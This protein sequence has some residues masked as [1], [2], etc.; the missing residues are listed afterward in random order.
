[1]PDQAVE[2]E[3]EIQLAKIREADE[4]PL[5]VAKNILR[6]A[7]FPQHPFSLRSVGTSQS[8]ERL[9]AKD[10]LAFRDRF[11]VAKNG[12]IAVFGNVRAP[13]V[14]QLLEQKLGA[15]PAGELALTEAPRPQPLRDSKTVRAER[16]K[17]QAVLMLGYQGAD[18][19][20]PD[21]YALE[22]I[23]EASSDMGSRF[24]IRI[25][26][27]MGLA[28]FVGAVQVQALVPGLFA[29]YLGTDPEKTE[30]VKKA[31][32]EEVHKLS[33]NGLTEL[34]LTRAK[35]KLVGQ[36]QIANQSNNTFAYMSAL[37]ELYGLGFD[38][39]K[40]LE[41]RVNAVGLADIKR[42]AAKYFA[43]QR[44]VLAIVQPPAKLRATKD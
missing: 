30:E 36:Q 20:D 2:R 26:E 19:F 35:K 29:F 5:S 6:A 17:M 11:V 1:M 22:L 40:E 39:Y 8:V 44:H 23:D 41:K 38:R 16:D 24:F 21:R 33:N 28:Y 9:T 43:Q 25:R 12:V 27:Q 10:L 34:E 3:R 42:V 31:F 13:D 37:D 7:L 14:K 32:L 4:Q 18:V 15:M